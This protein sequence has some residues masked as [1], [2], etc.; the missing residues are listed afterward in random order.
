M[1]AQTQTFAGFLPAI[2]SLAG[3]QNADEKLCECKNYVRHFTHPT[4]LNCKFS[5]PD[6]NTG[7]GLK[8]K[9]TGRSPYISQR[10]RT[11]GVK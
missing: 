5:T 1:F 3:G 6:I 9:N 4:G 2:L 10:R 7:T 11:N 8:N